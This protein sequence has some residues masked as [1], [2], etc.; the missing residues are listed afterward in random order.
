MV[1]PNR[2]TYILCTVGREP[3]ELDIFNHQDPFNHV[4][5]TYWVRIFQWIEAATALSGLTFY[6]VWDFQQIPDLPSY[7]EHVVAL[8][9]LDEYCAM[10]H[11]LNRVR[12]V[13][14]N[15]GFWPWLS[16][17]LR[18]KSL[19]TMLKFIKDAANW[20]GHYARAATRNRHLRPGPNRLVMPLGYARQTDV[21]VRRFDARRYVV[22]FLG[23][24]EQRRYRPLSP[25]AWLGTPKS[26]ARSVM[27]DGL[28]A[29]A[30]RMPNLVYLGSTESFDDSILS[31]GHRYSE[32]MSETKICLAPRGSSVETYRFFEA[33]R[34]GCVIICDRLPPHWFYEQCPAIQIDDWHD[35]E[36]TVDGLLADPGS[37][38]ALHLK[39]LE[40][41]NA[42]CSEE[43]VAK[44]MASCL[45]PTFDRASPAAR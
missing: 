36:E 3:I 7:G 2:C 29:L 37:F 25:Q 24:V 28:Q 38:L 20:A 5:L 39:T 17:T 6:V 14:K 15:Y 30:A 16:P 40:W 26:I 43:A 42:I 32:L 13:F 41:W 44:I 22:S 45:D 21:P 35:L 19:V 18:G 11:Y 31:D 23:S 8:L 9:L 33:M 12:F 10:P 27:V 4:Y 1:P 34:Q